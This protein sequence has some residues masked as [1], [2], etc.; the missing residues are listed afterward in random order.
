[1]FGTITLKGVQVKN[2]FVDE[3][4]REFHINNYWT[5][6]KVYKFVTLTKSYD[7]TWKMLRQLELSREIW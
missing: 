6:N 4:G 1:M 7:D 3:T 5:G 2:K